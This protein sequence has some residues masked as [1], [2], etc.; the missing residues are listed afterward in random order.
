MGIFWTLVFSSR[1]YPKPQ[2]R[3]RTIK[4]YKTNGSSKLERKLKRCACNLV[5]NPNL[6]FIQRKYTATHAPHST[7]STYC[8]SSCSSCSCLVC[9]MR[10]DHNSTAWGSPGSDDVLLSQVD[11]CDDFNTQ[12]PGFML[13]RSRSRRKKDNVNSSGLPYYI[14][15]HSHWWRWCLERGGGD[16]VTAWKPI[17]CC[18][19]FID[20]HLSSSQSQL[21][22]GVVT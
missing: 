1:F 9:R 18:L 15:L 13:Q 22:T 20:Y 5:S 17:C 11:S 19:V 2:T 14:W 4:P 3:L 16:L 21:L 8:T 10:G 12:Y 6:V 7:Y